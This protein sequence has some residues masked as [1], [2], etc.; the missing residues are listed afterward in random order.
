MAEPLF[1][2]VLLGVLIGVLFDILRLPRLVF[3]DKFFFDFLFWIIS[4]IAVFCY[5]LIFNNG[6]I[7]AIFLLFIAMG[8]L[9]VTFTLGYVSMPVQKRLADK[10]RKSL[11]SLKKVL[12][13]LHNMYYNIKAKKRLT[14]KK[15]LKGVK[16]GKGKRKKE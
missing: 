1:Y 10:I 6:D 4:A 14:E 11:K 3:R 7:R 16:N 9:L 12:Q 13:K 15:K 2:A 5:L 8:F